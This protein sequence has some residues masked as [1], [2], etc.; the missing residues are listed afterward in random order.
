MEQRRCQRGHIYDRE[1]YGDHCPY[2]DNGAT[3]IEFDR[4][5]TDIE[6]ATGVEAIGKSHAELI[7]T[8]EEIKK[9]VP[10]KD[11]IVR[12]EEIGRTMPVWP[13]KKEINPVVGWLVC[14][15]GSE[16]GKDYRLYGKTNKIGRRSDMDICIHGDDTI[17]SDSH[18]KIDYDILNNKFYLLPGNNTNT[19][20][21]NMTPVY[22]AH[23]LN[24]YDVLLFGRTELLFV[25]FCCEH[26]K[27]PLED[28]EV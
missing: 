6:E 5:F 12:Q 4:D 18:A 16:E 14:T 17:S 24:P 23:I 26:F 22:S 9:T 27:W 19:I 20:Y 10:P 2:C 13:M 28:R 25:P 7:I 8:P 1:I 3:S 21:L 15:K 11:Y